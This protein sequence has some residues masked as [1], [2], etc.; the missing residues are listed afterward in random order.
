MKTEITELIENVDRL[1][2]EDDDSVD[3]LWEPTLIQVKAALKEAYKPVDDAEVREVLIRLEHPKGWALEEC[4]M[5]TSLI[6][7]LALANAEHKRIEKRFA[8]ELGL[9]TQLEKSEAQIE[10]LK[11]LLDKIDAR[12]N[13]CARDYNAVCDQLKKMQ[14]AIDFTYATNR[15]SYLEQF[16]TKPENKG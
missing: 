4:E 8:R 3:E 6:E 2:N 12:R 10:G 1:L 15:A 13:Q 9:L 14:L 16:T 7:R 5:A 11:R